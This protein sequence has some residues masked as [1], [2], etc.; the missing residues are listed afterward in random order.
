MSAEVM[1]GAG[2]APRRARHLI[3]AEFPRRGEVIA[4]CAVLV[5]LGHLLF[6][7]LTFILAA[8]FVSVSKASRWRLWWLTV[9]AAAGLG[10]TLAIG[11]RAAAAGFAAGPAAILG[12]LS[13][14]GHPFTHLLH[15][16]GAFV[17]AGS[18]L[19]RQFPIALIAAAAEAALVGWLDWMHTDEWAVPPR[20]PGAIAAARGRGRRACHSRG[21]HAHQGR[22]RAGCRAG[23]RCPGAARLA[24]GRR[25]GPGH[26][27]GGAGDHGDQ[28][29]GSARRAAPPQAGDR[30]GPE[31]RRGGRGS[32]SRGLPGDRHTTAGF[33]D[34][35]RPLRAV[36]PCQP[37]PPADHDPCPAP[38][39]RPWR[40]GLPARR[41][42]ADRRDPRGLANPGP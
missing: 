36:Q 18:W 19:W 4:A 23:Q 20:R 15:P 41:V 26:R 38:R 8:V 3:P 31:R 11:P 42:R 12:Y 14:G 33:R 13:G 7:Q 2:P 37:G 6:A 5:L 32:G 25:R 16:H 28:P 21:G 24:R 10:W 17:G 35:G 1:P 22:I 27:R 34:R 39:L 30:G 9:P 29:A 40:P